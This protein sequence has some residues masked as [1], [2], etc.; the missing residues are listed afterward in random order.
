MHKD[1]RK[2]LDIIS[3][4]L[5]KETAGP[6][7]FNRR[8]LSTLLRTFEQIIDL[9]NEMHPEAPPIFF[10]DEAQVRDFPGIFWDIFERI[11]IIFSVKNVKTNH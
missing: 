9:Y 3:Q 6:R 11:M 2:L 5:P 1:V 4:S 7:L 10:I 8:D